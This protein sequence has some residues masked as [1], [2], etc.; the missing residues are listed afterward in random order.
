M[1]KIHQCKGFHFG[2]NDI[3]VSV[4]F[5]YGNYCDNYNNRDDIEKRGDPTLQ[6]E[7]SDAE[8]AI[9]LNGGEWITGQFMSEVLNEEPDDVRGHCTPE[10]VLKALNWAN[11][12]PHKEGLR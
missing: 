1:F 5:G 2:V 10:V 9:W 4:Q 3:T 11:N 7:S 12:Y 6:V 8:I